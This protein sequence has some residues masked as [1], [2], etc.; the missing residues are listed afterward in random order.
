M[1]SR[2]CK[3]WGAHLKW[4]NCSCPFVFSSSCFY[5]CF[6]FM[7]PYAK[8][9]WFICFILFYHYYSHPS[10]FSHFPNTTLSI[11][12]IWCSA[13]FKKH[14]FVM[15]W[16]SHN[17]QS[18]CF[19]VQQIHSFIKH[20]ADSSPTVSQMLC[21]LN[22]LIVFCVSAGPLGFLWLGMYCRMSSDLVHP[23]AP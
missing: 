20:W 2:T 8:F 10:L 1:L 4:L 21:K 18:Q 19:L 6:F 23:S 7:P 5:F 13:G 3:H 11:W 14:P 9:I 17:F 16:P 22:M 15:Q 12:L